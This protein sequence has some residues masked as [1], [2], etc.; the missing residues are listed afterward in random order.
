M[1]ASWV[2]FALFCEEFC[3]NVL[4]P[5]PEEAKL[6]E[7][8][9]RIVQATQ[10]ALDRKPTTKQWEKDEQK[11]QRLRKVPIKRPQSAGSRMQ[12]SRTAAPRQQWASSGD[13]AQLSRWS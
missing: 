10:E 12:S 8:Q 7:A 3:D 13:L 9:L 6:S 11:Q 5:G 1:L 4:L 2:T